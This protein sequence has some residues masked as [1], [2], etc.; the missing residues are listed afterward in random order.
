MAAKDDA[1]E[2]LLDRRSYLKLAGSAVAATAASSAA[3]SA[4]T[5]VVGYGGGGFGQSSYGGGSS[6][7]TNPVPTID[8]FTIAKSEQLGTDRMFT[9][10]WSVSDEAEDLDAVEVVVIDDTAEMNFAVTEV[11]GASASGWKVFQFPVDSTVDVTLRVTDSAGNVSKD[12]KTV[13]L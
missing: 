12:T 8:E 5:E 6:G 3:G 7:T 1:E 9:V 11:S 4:E 2:S 10:K 13:T